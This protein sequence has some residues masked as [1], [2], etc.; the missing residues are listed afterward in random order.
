MRVVLGIN[1]CFAVGRWPRPSDWAPI[2]R[3]RLG[4]DVVQV[5]LDLVDLECGDERLSEEAHRHRDVLQEA[6]LRVHSTH[7]G[8]AV[9]SSNLLLHPE[10]WERHH[11]RLWYERAITFT[12][13]IEAAGTGGH[14]GAFSVP[15]W[16]DPHRRGMLWAELRSDLEELAAHAH[17]AGESFFLVENRA[18]AREPATM[19]Q[20]RELLTDG[21]GDHVPVRLCLDVGH[22]CAPGMSGEDLDP[23]A[24]LRSMGRFASCVQLQQSDAAGDRHWPFTPARNRDGRIDA[25]RV[26]DALGEG[27]VAESTLVIEVM[28][29]FEQ[30]DDAVVDDLAT[31]VDYWRESLAR[32]G[33]LVES[34]PTSL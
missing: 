22:Q 5:S 13:A 31:S 12:A 15:D 29:A 16:R 10:A 27:H 20:V 34:R 8:S 32:R 18:G 2:V 28:P 19:E 33:V 23:Y 30:D 26:I 3:Q 11:A 9:S 21:D 17:R 25:D 7:T 4:L 14:V 6:G 24:W 1:T